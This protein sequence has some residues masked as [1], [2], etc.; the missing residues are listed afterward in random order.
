MCYDVDKASFWYDSCYVCDNGIPPTNDNKCLVS[1]TAG[2]S[3]SVWN[4]HIID[5]TTA[6]ELVNSIN[7]GDNDRRIEIDF[8]PLFSSQD[9]YCGGVPGQ[10]N[11]K[12]CF[13]SI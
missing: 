10:V 12:F 4:D 13:F 7:V 6:T 11:R 9:T 2:S 5:P 3:S 1:T 8:D